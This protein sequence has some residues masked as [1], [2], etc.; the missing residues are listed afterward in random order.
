MY[1]PFSLNY[2]LTA[3]DSI[4]VTDLSCNQIIAFGRYNQG[5]LFPLMIPPGKKAIYQVFYCQNTPRYTMEY[6]LT[7]TRVWERPLDHAEFIIKLSTDM[8]L[9]YMSI[10]W[11]S[12][13]ISSSTR[14]YFIT[15]QQYMPDSNLVV[16][17]SRR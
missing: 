15:R 11:D 8:L 4:V 7:T 2:D 9:K 16:E 14:F 13:K 10:P 17:W 3:P 1:Y 6:I 5:I 12:V